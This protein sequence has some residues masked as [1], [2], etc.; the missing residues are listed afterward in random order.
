MLFQGAGV[1]TREKAA[2]GRRR[3]ISRRG[4]HSLRHTFATCCAKAN[5]PEGAVRDWL[6]HS[7]VMVTR[8]YEHWRMTD[9]QQSILAALRGM[10]R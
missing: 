5:V 10:P 6:G 4:F 1:E 8:I 2:D 9:G 3:V 7:S